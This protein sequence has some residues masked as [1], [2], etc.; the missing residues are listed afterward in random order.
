MHS[1]LNNANSNMTRKNGILKKSLDV[2][3]RE[4]GGAG[5]C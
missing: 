5:S 2:N 4:G 1:S 3:N